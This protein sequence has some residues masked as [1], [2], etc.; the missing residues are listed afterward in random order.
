MEIS[1]EI[2]SHSCHLDLKLPLLPASKSYKL[3]FWGQVNSLIT[4][5]VIYIM[6]P[7]D[8][9]RPWHWASTYQSRVC[10][11]VMCTTI[12]HCYVGNSSSLFLPSMH[13]RRK[14]CLDISD[15]NIA[16]AVLFWSEGTYPRS[17]PHSHI[18]DIYTPTANSIFSL[19]HFLLLPLDSAYYASFQNYACHILTWSGLQ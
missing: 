2:I 19:E 18:A 6:M 4:A 7:W 10:G 17:P 8:P 16:L 3:P 12:E 15:W 13:T 14:P 5:I 11:N 9:P 1:P